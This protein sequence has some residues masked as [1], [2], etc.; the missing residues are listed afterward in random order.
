LINNAIEGKFDN[1]PE[2]EQVV[3]NILKKHTNDKK[4]HEAIS[5]ALKTKWIKENTTLVDDIELSEE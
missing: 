5:E 4:I 2:L 3:S 1:N